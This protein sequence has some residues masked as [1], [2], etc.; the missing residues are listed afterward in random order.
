MP[1]INSVAAMRRSVNTC[2]FQSN[3]KTAVT[4]LICIYCCRRRRRRRRSPFAIVS[5]FARAYNFSLGF[6]FGDVPFDAAAPLDN[7]RTTA[8]H[9]MGN[10]HLHIT[11]TIPRTVLHLQC[12]CV[13]HVE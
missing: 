2:N 13:F 10:W 11:T 7:G 6:R 3:R 9:R 12:L 5:A 8:Q 1:K 4:L